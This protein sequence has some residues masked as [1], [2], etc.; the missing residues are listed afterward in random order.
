[1]IFLSFR[2]KIK[3]QLLRLTRQTSYQ[4]VRNLSVAKKVFVHV[5]CMMRRFVIDL[6]AVIAL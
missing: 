2:N 6:C 3:A 1:M 5:V 4:W